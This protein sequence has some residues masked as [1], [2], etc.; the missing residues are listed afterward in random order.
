M[1]CSSMKAVNQYSPPDCRLKTTLKA[2]Q[3]IRM[4]VESANY[5]YSTEHSY[6]KIYLS[7]YMIPKN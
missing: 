3:I 1:L 4:I 5:Y 2:D 6:L 7:S